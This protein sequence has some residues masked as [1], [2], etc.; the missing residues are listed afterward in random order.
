MQEPKEIALE[1]AGP[2]VDQVKGLL[3]VPPL[4]LILTVGVP[5]IIIVGLA[6][7]ACIKCC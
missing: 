5:L 2:S 4:M 7:F 3:D 1:K 6:V